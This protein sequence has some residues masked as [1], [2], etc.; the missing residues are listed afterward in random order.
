M[1]KILCGGYEKGLEVKNTHN[2]LSSDAKPMSIMSVIS[3]G[4][5]ERAF[6]DAM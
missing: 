3:L 1:A 5:S 2:T 4:W 6:M